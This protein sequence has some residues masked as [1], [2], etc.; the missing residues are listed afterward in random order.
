M[1]GAKKGTFYF[2]LPLRARPWG[3][4]GDCNPSRRGT[5]PPAVAAVGRAAGDARADRSDF[6][7]GLRLIDKLRSVAGQGNRAGCQERGV[8]ALLA[9][10]EARPVPVLRLPHEATVSELAG[11]PLLPH[12]LNRVNDRTKDDQKSQDAAQPQIRRPIAGLHDGLISLP[13]VVGVNPCSWQRV[14][15]WG[16]DI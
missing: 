8:G 2:V 12:S 9:Q 14:G 5:L 7:F 16:R 3:R 13:G 6:P 10:A 15:R 4:S 11:W 1:R